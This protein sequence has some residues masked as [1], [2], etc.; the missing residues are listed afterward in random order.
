MRRKKSGSDRSHGYSQRVTLYMRR[1][2]SDL[3]M[4]C[5]EKKNK[6][7][8]IFLR[9]CRFYPPLVPPPPP[10]PPSLAVGT[11]EEQRNII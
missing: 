10:P 7:D 3:R 4:R 6:P 9:D 11:S 8:K 2:I 1:I 5:S